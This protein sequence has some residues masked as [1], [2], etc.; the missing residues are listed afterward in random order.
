VE[1]NAS[2][3][4]WPRD[5]SFRSWARRLPNRFTMSVKAPRGLTHGAKLYRPERSLEWI[6]RCWHELGAVRGVLL[7]QLLA[8][9]AP[10]DARLEYFLSCVPGWVRVAVEFR[11]HSW[12]D[13][14]VFA[15]L[16]RYGVGYCVVSGAGLPCVLRATA[17]FVYIRLHGLT[18][19]GSTRVSTPRPIWAGGRHGWRNGGQ[20]G[21]MCTPISTMTATGTRCTTHAD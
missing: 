5:N 9:L 14:T 2:F 10:D 17:P 7:I 18:G 12:H 16:E 3:Y 11:H 4:R 15:L 19:S 21:G 8:G 6:G 13:E 20:P 1:L